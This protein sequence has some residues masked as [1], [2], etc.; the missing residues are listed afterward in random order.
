MFRR[1]WDTGTAAAGLRAL[2]LLLGIFFVAMAVNKV[3]W[4]SDS[5]LL[6]RR[7]QQWLPDPVPLVQWYLETIAIP[8]APLFAR[9]VP[10]GEFA[11][12]VALMVGFHSRWAAVLALFMVINFHFATGS[13]FE[14]AF[15]REGNGLPVLAGL[16][17]IAAG[18]ARL[19]WS[20]RG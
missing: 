3:A 2:A 5:S 16:L 11:T 7:F 20:L 17:A 4:I 12:G 10:L 1:G 15:L 9:L 6:M 19:P 8:G 18:G 14:W 13:F